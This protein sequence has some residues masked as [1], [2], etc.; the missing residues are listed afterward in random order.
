MNV[1]NT[2]YFRLEYDQKEQQL[3]QIWTGFADSD[4]FIKAI[5][6]TVDFVKENPVR[7]IISDTTNQK[8]VKPEDSNYAASKLPVMFAA[9]VQAMAFVLPENIFTKM[10]LKGFAEA[11]KSDRVEFFASV[12]DAKTWLSS[13]K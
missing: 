4:T 5:D 6:K 9:G 1:I 3:V 10:S 12:Y 7:T 11:K 13:Y 8:V 2:S